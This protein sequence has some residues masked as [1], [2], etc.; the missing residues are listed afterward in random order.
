MKGV[1][2]FIGLVLLA[3]PAVSALDAFTSA[4]IF[5]LKI[6]GPFTIPLPASLPQL[7]LKLGAPLL[8]QFP[9]LPLAFILNP[10]AL[11]INLQFSAASLF[12]LIL[13]IGGLS[14]CF[15]FFQ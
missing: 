14:I 2:R 5:I 15:P 9:E 8:A 12:P 1:A 6:S 10:S 4:S 3:L 11:P 13:K 7:L